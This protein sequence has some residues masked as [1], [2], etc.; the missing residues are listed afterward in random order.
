ML[1]NLH[2]IITKE[3]LAIPERY[4]ELIISMRTAFAQE[5][6]LDKKQTSY[7]DSLDALRLG[8]SACFK[9]R[10]FCLQISINKSQFIS[11]SS[12]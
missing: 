10:T 9:T 3:Y 7:D 2:A 12:E 5:L 6:S 4:N 11:I 1:S 8:L